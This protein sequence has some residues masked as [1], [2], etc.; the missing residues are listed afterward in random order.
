MA[1]HGFS[2]APAALRPLPRPIPPHLLTLPSP[3]CLASS[4]SSSLV[5]S[6]GLDSSLVAA[7]AVKHLKESH[8]TFDMGRLKTFSVGLEG[9][10]DLAAAR[11]VADFLGTD[12][13]E[14]TFTV[15]EGID[16]LKEV[17]WHLE[18]YEQVTRRWHAGDWF[19]VGLPH[20]ARLATPLSHLTPLIQP[21]PLRPSADALPQIRAATPMYLLCRRIRAMG[22][23]MILSG[24][25]ADE[26]F[27]GYLYFHKA[28]S[29]EEFHK[30]CVRKTSRLHQVRWTDESVPAL[31]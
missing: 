7:V 11:K 16:S 22:L 14:V 10:P 30:E 1:S 28:P 8:N 15:Q 24:E 20:H 23:K 27:G 3:F 18:S 31:S 21:S 25:G 6:G 5:Q 29:P 13:T 9:S 4:L 2:P 17:I 26:I 19:R 12:H